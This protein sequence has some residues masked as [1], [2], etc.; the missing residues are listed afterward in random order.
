MSSMD[1]LLAV[2]R[3]YYT[4]LVDPPTSSWVTRT[5]STFYVL[6]VLIIGPMAFLTGLVR[7][8]RRPFRAR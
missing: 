1:G 5:A 7:R 6:A 3:W 2:W 4:T 8:P